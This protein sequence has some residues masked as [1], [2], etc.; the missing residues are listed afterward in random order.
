MWCNNRWEKR[1]GPLGGC[2]T[3]AFDFALSERKNKIKKKLAGPLGRIQSEKRLRP[4][5]E[6][7]IKLRPPRFLE[8][9]T[10]SAL[11][12]V[13]TKDPGPAAQ[14]K[15]KIQIIFIFFFSSTS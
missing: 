6:D 15:E 2:C 11:L 13:T 1:R 5:R 3:T 12:R 4:K 8:P 7:G 9:T 14:G 10:A